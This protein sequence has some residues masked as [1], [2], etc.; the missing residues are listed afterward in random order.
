M[1]R[2]GALLGLLAVGCCLSSGVRTPGVEA[3]GNPQ[4]HAAFMGPGIAAWPAL[5]QQQTLR[6]SR[7]QQQEQ[8]QLAA[9]RRPFVG[10]NWKCN[11]TVKGAEDIIQMLNDAPPEVDDVWP[12]G[13]GFC[14]FRVVIA[15]PSLHAGSLLHSLR[16]PFAVGLQ[17]SSTVKGFGAF[18]G[19]LSPQMAKLRSWGLCCAPLRPADFGIKS[20][21]VGHSER[22][23]GFN[24]QP[25][26]S[27]EVVAAKAK[28]AVEA[29]LQVIAC[30]GES[31]E[32]RQ[33]GRTMDVLG[34]QLQAYAAA[35]S[36][37]DWPHVVIAY[38]P[39]W[40]IGTGQTATPET[41]ASG[42]V[43]TWAPRR[44][45]KSASSTEDQ[46]RAQTLRQGP[47]DS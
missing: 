45:R 43:N 40:A 38:E 21:I 12:L 47:Q 27:N 2:C 42:C 10:G 23:A 19:E 11:G 33:K 17:D 28:N 22:R 32:D 46:S 35:L 5:Q 30:I 15:P 16:R 39:I 44:R 14:G 7:R 26:E 36:A 25:K 20:V 8:Q 31:L 13:F 37:S 4:Q 29:G 6:C 1:G 24:N 34:Q 9:A 3:L 18:T 41:S